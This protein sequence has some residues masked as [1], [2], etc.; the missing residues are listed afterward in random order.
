MTLDYKR[1]INFL[2]FSGIPSIGFPSI[3]PVK[4]TEIHIGEGS[5]AVNLVQ[6]YLNVKLFGFS[7]SK[8][9]NSQ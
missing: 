7:T 5:T 3:E 8:I 2:I 4:V 9:S 6:N 1:E